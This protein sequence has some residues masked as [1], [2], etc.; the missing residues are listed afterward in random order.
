[1]PAE[2]TQDNYILIIFSELTGTLEYSVT[3][4]DQ[5][6]VSHTH[7][8]EV[9]VYESAIDLIHPVFSVSPIVTKVGGLFL[10]YTAEISIENNF[11]RYFQYET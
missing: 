10:D 9:I 8:L 11:P 7:T 2:I 4:I 1:L 5:Y 6:E 3:F